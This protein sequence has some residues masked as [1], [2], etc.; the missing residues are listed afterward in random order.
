MP[1]WTLCPNCGEP[2]YATDHDNGCPKMTVA[3]ELKRIIQQLKNETMD[4][5]HT[6]ASRAFAYGMAVGTLE[7]AL[8][9]WERKLAGGDPSGG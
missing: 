7:T 3:D 1:L 8:R 5:D 9:E 6:T 2:K 4:G